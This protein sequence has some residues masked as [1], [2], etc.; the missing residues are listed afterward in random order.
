ME[1]PL[2]PDETGKA[3]CGGNVGGEVEGEGFL[4]AGEKPQNCMH[5]PP[6]VV[7]AK[8]CCFRSPA[9]VIHIAALTTAKTLITTRL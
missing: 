1:K 4:W 9:R 3:G 6:L 8:S 5:R 2:A 7:H